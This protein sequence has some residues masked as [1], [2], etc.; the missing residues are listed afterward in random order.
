MFLPD[1]QRALRLLGEDE[2]DPFEL[3]DV[4]T[5]AVL[6]NTLQEAARC[7][8]GSHRSTDKQGFYIIIHIS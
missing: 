8:S 7:P 4:P 5:D 6:K 3:T 2:G 1:S